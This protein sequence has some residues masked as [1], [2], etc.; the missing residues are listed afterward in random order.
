MEIEKNKE[1]KGLI[2]AGMNSSDGKTLVTCLLLSALKRINRLNFTT[3][4]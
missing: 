4:E 1:K 2:V 3:R